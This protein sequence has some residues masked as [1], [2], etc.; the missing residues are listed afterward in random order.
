MTNKTAHGTTKM[1]VWLN[2]RLCDAKSARVSVMDHGFLYGDG[3]YETVHVYNYRVYHWPAHYRRL[4]ESARKLELRVPWPSAVLGRRVIQVAKANRDPDASVRITIARGPGPLGLDPTVC[5]HPTLVML[6]HPKRDVTRYQRN[7]ISIGI[8][9]IR[10]NHPRCLDPIIKSNN[11][12]NTILA[13]ME[14]QKM[15]VFEAV[16]LNLDGY[17]TEG[18]TSN[19]FFVRRGEIYTPALECGLL[20]GITRESVIRLAKKA[21]IPIH[22]GRYTPSALLRA[23]EVFVSSTTLE[24]APVVKVMLAGSRRSYQIADGRLGP[25]SQRILQLFKRELAEEVRRPS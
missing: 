5:P 23:D 2:N 4:M 15:G 11:S 19:I 13:K 7:G 25:V 18:T 6:L 20:A 12:L 8:T 9:A 14:A 1:K 16:L 17:L 24:I 22:E 3:I 21:R 10:R